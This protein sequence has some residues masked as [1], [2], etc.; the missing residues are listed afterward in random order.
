DMEKA[1]PVVRAGLRN[2][3][4]LVVWISMPAV[5]RLGVRASSLAPDLVPLLEHGEREVRVAAA[6]ALCAMDRATKPTVT[7]MAA[8]L[9]SED[10]Y[11][12]S[13]IAKALARL[14]PDAGHAVPALVHRLKA[15]ELGK[16]FT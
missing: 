9:K 5:E 1:L 14:G 7:A 10:E 6:E 15:K 11:E 16:D 13:R 4:G 2:S 8:L 3:E 12:R